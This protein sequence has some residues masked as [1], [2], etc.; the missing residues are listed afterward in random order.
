MYL[1]FIFRFFFYYDNYATSTRPITAEMAAATGL[2]RALGFFKIFI[3]LY[4]PTNDYLQVDYAYK[5]TTGARDEPLGTF[6]FRHNPTNDQP[7]PSSLHKHQ[8]RNE[9]RLGKFLFLFLKIY[10]LFSTY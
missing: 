10:S 8:Y 5:M 3:Y 1:F 7:P 2:R 4:I 9:C 6:L